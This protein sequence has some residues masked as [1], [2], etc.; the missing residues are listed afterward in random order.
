MKEEQIPTI[1]VSNV[2]DNCV[3]LHEGEVLSCDTNK[4]T[5]K[6]TS[7]HAITGRKRNWDGRKSSERKSKVQ[8]DTPD[9]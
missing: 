6:Q 9:D 7:E 5:N 4:Q 2:A 3:I 1:E 8:K